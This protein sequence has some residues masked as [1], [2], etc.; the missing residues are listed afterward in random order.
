M[1]D[2]NEIKKDNEQLT[3]ALSYVTSQRPYDQ[4]KQDKYHDMETRYKKELE[5]LQKEFSE[6]LKEYMEL[7]KKYY[8]EYVNIAVA[9]NKERQASWDKQMNEYESYNQTS[10]VERRQKVEREQAIWNQ[11]RDKL[12]A[13]FDNAK[14]QYQNDI[15][16]WEAKKAERKRVLKEAES[17]LEASKNSR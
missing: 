5:P 2:I 9:Q 12:N 10:E 11:E 1:S 14:T 17:G 4:D 13:E 6:K 3:Q 8:G 15:E 7:S 16:A